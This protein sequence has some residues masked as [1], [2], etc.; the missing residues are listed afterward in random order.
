[1]RHQAGGQVRLK[2]ETKAETY[3]CM[4]EGQ[5]MNKV[6]YQEEKFVHYPKMWQEYM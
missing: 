2:G 3:S 5:T 1:M 6:I 4:E